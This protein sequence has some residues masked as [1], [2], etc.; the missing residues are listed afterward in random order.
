[1]SR[2]IP[3]EG[4]NLTENPSAVP[5]NLLAAR[6]QS[7]YVEFLQVSA[8]G[9]LVEGAKNHVVLKV[10]F[11]H[12]TARCRGVRISMDID[13]DLEL[14]DDGTGLKPGK[15]MVKPVSYR[16]ASTSSARSFELPLQRQTTLQAII[17][18]FVGYG[19]QDFYF[20]EVADRY[21]GCRDF[22]YVS[23]R[24]RSDLAGLVFESSHIYSALGMRFQSGL[25]NYCPID[26]GE[27]SGYI[28][29]EEVYMPYCR[30]Q[31]Q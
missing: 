19:L 5:N 12:I 28:R 9:A 17:S 13:Q 14:E 3:A 11:E 26:K 30:A 22:M 27:F 29:V 1:M 8:Q 10:D 25:T 15:M 20:Q 7:L 18:P 16:G 24:T 31:D 4:F 21:Y 6:C 23:P 2:A